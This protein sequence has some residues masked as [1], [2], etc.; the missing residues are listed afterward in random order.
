MRNVNAALLLV[1]FLA[2]GIVQTF[3]QPFR[4]VDQVYE[5]DNI[6]VTKNINVATVTGTATD[7]VA[8][9]FTVTVDVYQP[10]PSLDTTAERPLLLLTHGGSFLAGNSP[11]QP[12]IPLGTKEDYWLT[13]LARSFAKRGWVVGV[14]TYRVGWS[15]TSADAEVRKSTIIQAAFR[16]ISDGKAV[17]R[18]FHKT[19]VDDGN[20]YQIDTSRIAMGG[21]QAGGYIPTN[22]IALDKDEDFV[23][24]PKLQNP[25]NIPYVDTCA[26]GTAWAPGN[27]S[28]PYPCLGK[29]EGQGNLG[30]SD[31]FHVAINIAGAMLDTVYLEAGDIPMLALHG[32][33]DPATPFGTAVV[34]VAA[35]GDPVV[36][37]S[38]S[39][40]II[41]RST[42]LG[43]QAAL[44]P[45]F[46]GDGYLG[47]SLP[48][49]YA[50]EGAGFQPYS[51]YD[52]STPQEE[53]E[54]RAYLDTVETFLS[55]RLIQI[56]DLPENVAVVVSRPE[57][58]QFGTALNL[59]PN[60]SAGQLTVRLDANAATLTGLNVRNLTGQ[61]VHS[62]QLFSNQEQVDLSALL[63]G[64]YLLEV[65]TDR[66]TEA[67]KVILQ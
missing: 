42:N 66:G 58:V 23:D 46:A 2:T 54:A 57:G 6:S 67:R 43:N 20:P 53:A 63:G 15:P 49:L 7:P 51:W 10:D 1:G 61:L 31:K 33:D 48:G 14:F 37:V 41:R 56:L 17:V 5:D 47:E 4:Y 21:S 18:F 60:P 3:A 34:L 39:L 13:D 64:I 16:A 29:V 9:P 65:I 27:P 44:L 32:T 59:Y 28:D 24:D 38:G 55:P 12:A 19:Y 22:Y 26:I 11:F 35:T 40:D 62:Q 52:D 50:F 25:N 8:G 45:E 36:E 30:Y